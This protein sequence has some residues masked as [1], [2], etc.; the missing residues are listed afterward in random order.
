MEPTKSCFPVPGTDHQITL[1]AEEPHLQFGRTHATLVIELDGR[2]LA[3]GDI[4]VARD[5]QRIQMIK[6]AFEQLDQGVV[7][8]LSEICLKRKLDEFCRTIHLSRRHPVQAEPMSGDPEK[9]SARHVLTPF[10]PEAGGAFL[11]GPPESGK[12]WIALVCAV[13][14]D[15]GASRLWAVH[16]TRTLFVN[17]ERSANSIAGRLAGVNR[18]LGL[19]VDRGLFCLNARGHDL[20]SVT[21]ALQSAIREGVGCVVLDSVSRAGYGDLTTDETANQIVNALNQLGVPWLAV[22]HTPR[23]DSS[24]IFGSVHFEAGADVMV[25][26]ESEL[27]PGGTR[28]IRLEITKAND[29][30]RPPAQVLAL[31][32]DPE[33]GLERVRPASSGE[34]PTLGRTLRFPRLHEIRSHLLDRGKATT[35]GIANA[36][37]MD[38]S[39]VSKHLRQHPDIFVETERSGREVYYSV[40]GSTNET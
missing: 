5:D 4:A 8:H 7:Y 1:R 6:S 18:V 32:F 34:F 20:A 35:T 25:R 2:V 37:N 27:S 39:N 33:A 19:P 21:G 40:L 36:L 14:I 28:G 10:I 23:A 17:L 31:E 15:A 38:A 3:W 26:L 30:A 11:Y 13:S 22:A 16:R 24:H 29:F 12:S 9:E